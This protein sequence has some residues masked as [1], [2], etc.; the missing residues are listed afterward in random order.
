MKLGA[1]SSCE[2]SLYHGR[3]EIAAGV[4][5]METLV[6]VIAGGMPTR[7]EVWWL[8][9]VARTVGDEAMASAAPL[10]RDCEPMRR[11]FCCAEDET[12]CLE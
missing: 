1:M 11:T 4:E 2:Y 3:Q 9:A 8:F 6:I 7:T 10:A 12:S 5:V